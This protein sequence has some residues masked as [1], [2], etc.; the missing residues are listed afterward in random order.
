MI[1][2]E[3]LAYVRQ[4]LNAGTT[5]EQISLGLKSNGWTDEDITQAFNALNPTPPP[6]APTP[7]PV[8][9]PTAV[10]QPVANSVSTP[11]T[12]VQ[13]TINTFIP[14]IQNQ[15]VLTSQNKKSK[16]WPYII[17]F[18]LV[19]IIIIGVVVYLGYK[20]TVSTVSMLGQSL[21]ENI[22]FYEH[23]VPYVKVPEEQNGYFAMVD[24]SSTNII[25][26][27]VDRDFLTQYLNN[28][29]NIEKLN[30]KEAERILSK[31]DS[32]ID[33]FDGVT[34]KEYFQCQSGVDGLDCKLSVVRNLSQ[35]VGLKALYLYNTGKAEEAKAYANKII[36]LGDMTSASGSDLITTLVGLAV[37][38]TGYKVLNLVEGDSVMDE[39][40]KESHISK[41]REFHRDGMKKEYSRAIEFIEYVDDLNKP[42]SQ[43]MYF[44]SEEEINIF[45]TAVKDS[46]LWDSF[47]TKKL[48][49]DSLLIDLENIDMPCGTPYKNSH[50][51]ISIN[52]EEFD[53]D[54]DASQVNVGEFMYEMGHLT[55]EAY[56][57]KSCEIQDL[58]KSL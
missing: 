31:Y 30:L 41:I 48:F 28:Y 38:N 49:Y 29:P 26:D 21:T 39:A 43:S 55:Y 8:F 9:T 19:P 7:P 34:G 14:P 3:I 40:E 27:E 23:V 37:H 15:P 33:V 53:F 57:K 22:A 1:N 32:Y 45:R 12:T 35:V 25:S 24:L 47:A 13:P 44:Q 6:P 56:I 42:T 11:V 46:L 36:K 18:V 17:G 5:R 2:G 20:K 10:T 50:K 51:E 52:M 58:I 54:N 16:T 4:Q